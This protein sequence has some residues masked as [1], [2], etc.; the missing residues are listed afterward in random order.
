VGENKVGEDKVGGQGREEVEKSCRKGKIGK[1]VRSGHG[2]GRL[3]TTNL[4]KKE[5]G[6]PNLARTSLSGRPFTIVVFCND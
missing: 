4:R 3:H 6:R 5:V 1:G 2:N